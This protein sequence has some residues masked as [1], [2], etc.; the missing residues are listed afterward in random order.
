MA[1]QSISGMPDGTAGGRGDRV[2]IMAGEHKESRL[3]Y[4]R[5]A[6]AIRGPFPFGQISREILL[7]R[8]RAD[9]EL[10]HDREQ[11]VKLASQPRLQPD[12]LRHAGTEAGQQRL[13]L[14]RL[15]EDERQRDR[16]GP[17]GDAADAER[18]RADRRNI[19]SF[20]VV[21]HRERTPQSAQATPSDERN[22]LVPV[23]AALVVVFVVA[24]VIGHRPA[25]PGAAHNCQSSPAPGINWNG[26]DMPDRDLNHAELQ[27]AKLGSSMLARADLR[28]ANLAK[29]DLSYANLE[30]ANLSGARLQNA[31][32]KGA[33]LRAANLSMSD[34]H[35][36][37]LGYADLLGAN[38]AGANLAGARLG[39][40]IWTDGRIC[41]AGSVGDCR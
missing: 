10:S 36:A 9:D 13:T 40:A 6:D 18:R 20:D 2:K 14:A 26:C 12:I 22:L 25:A 1:A 16:R 23:G 29:A 37:D 35:D 30:S 28:R 24:Y 8:L 33:V 39:K 17:D 31:G 19:E 3:W 32:L 38:P 34:L 15:R 21:A 41:S 7:G 27:G 5:R 4:V 11:W